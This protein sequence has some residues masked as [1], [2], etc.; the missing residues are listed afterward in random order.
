MKKLHMIGNAHLDLAWLWPW[1]EGFGEA[2]ATFLSALQ[3]LDEFEGFIFTSSSAQY[4][5]WI[6]ENAPEMFERIQQRIKEGRWII[7]GG[8]WVQP[9]CNLPG[10]ESFVRQGL[11]GQQYFFNRFGVTATVGYNVDSFG[12][13]AGLPQIL[14]KSGMDSYLFLRPGEHEMKL[15]NGPFQWHGID[16][17]SVTACRIPVNYSSI[18]SLEGQIRDA[19]D[20]FPEKSNHFICF[21]GVGNH[22]GGPT[23]ANIRHILDNQQIAADCRLVFS[24]PRQYFDAVAQE[25]A[26]LPVVEGELQH[27]SPGCYSVVSKI[28]SLNRKAEHALSEAEIFS[29]L[30]SRL[31][32]SVKCGCSLDEAWKQTLTCQFHDILAGAGIRQVCDDAVH[33]LGGV[34]AAADRTA[35]HALQAISFAVNIP[36]EEGSQPLVVFNPHS[37]PLKTLIYHEK[38]SWGNFSYPDPCKVVR[39]DGMAVPYQF[40]RLTAQLD[41]RKRIAILAELP[42]LGY[43][44]FRITSAEEAQE[45]QPSHPDHI[46]ENEQVRIVINPANGLLTSYYD[47]SSGTELLATTTG[48]FLA[49]EDPTDTWAHGANRFDGL[50]RSAEFLSLTR[51]E[52]GPVLQKVQVLFRIGNSLLRQQYSLRADSNMLDVETELNWQERHCC[53]KV[54]YDLAMHNPEAFWETP[55]GAIHRATD[56]LEEP[57]QSWMDVSGIAGNGKIC[58]L[59]IAS[60]GIG[61]SHVKDSTLALTLLRSPVYAHHAPHPLE[62]SAESYDYTDQGIQRYHYCLM[63]HM[64]S[65]QN[66]SV[67]REA[68]L[69][70]RPAVKITETFHDGNLPGQY[71]G[72]AIDADNVLLSC[73]KPAYN[74]DGVILRLWEACGRRTKTTV[75]LPLFE[76]CIAAEFAP[77]EVKTWR[78]R[79]SRPAEECLLTELE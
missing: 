58:G 79:T 24:D 53:L 47:K 54:Y 48:Y 56:G 14:S 23:I 12:H 57:M 60:T 22:G 25:N 65:W 3:R 29:V 69:L 71:Q 35:N 18:I 40:M 33:T 10:A 20:R 74:G 55:F 39:S 7:C 75:Q 1:Q 76:Q 73:L 45:I 38:G 43:E 78:L 30:A 50:A 68:L 6:E 2:K 37:F 26:E 41:E 61:G 17:S 77:F 59:S 13:N 28:K 8:W 15:P 66:G 36:H 46:L 19:L 27:H 64:G 31:P 52:D 67:V 21:Y 34:C 5:A 32:V 4:Y 16:G 9:D 11:Y 62:A 72:I 44:T 49:H 42:P 51:L 70:N 63:P